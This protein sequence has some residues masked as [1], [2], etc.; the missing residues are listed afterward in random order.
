MSKA[1]NFE[2]MLEERPEDAL[3]YV[4]EF[5]DHVFWTFF[6]LKMRRELRVSDEKLRRGPL[7]EILFT[8]GY[9]QGVL[10]G[11][12]LPRQ[13]I[14]ELKDDIALIKEAEKIEAARQPEEKKE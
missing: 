12:E 5:K 3:K 14:G 6:Q 8:R 2:T 10:Y 13:V 1:E 11:L 9:I 7:D 4:E